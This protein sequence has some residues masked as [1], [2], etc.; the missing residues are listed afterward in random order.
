M[1]KHSRLW[2][3]FL[4]FVSFS[5]LAGTGCTTPDPSKIPSNN[6]IDTSP[7]ADVDRPNNTPG[8]TGVPDDTS[9][10]TDTGPPTDTRPPDPY[11]D[12]ESTATDPG[13]VLKQGT[14]GTLL[15]GIVLTPD[16]ILNPGE[17]LFVDTMIQCVATDCTTHADANNATWIDTKGVISPGLIDSHNHVAYNFL[18]QWF[19]NPFR[20]YSNRYQ[21][22]DE[23]SYEDH[24]RPYAK[25]RS[26]GTH[27]CPAAKWGEL[28]SLIHA[29]TTIQGQSFNQ[30]CINWGVRNADTN[31]HGLGYAHMA[32]NIGSPRDITDSQAAGYMERFKREVNPTT[33]FAVHMTEGIADNN[34]LLEFDSF[35]GRDPRPNRHQGVSLLYNGTSVLIH[36]M[37]MTD[38]QIEEAHL[39]N[40]KV[41]WSP[42]SQI[43]LYG[44]TTPI[45]R[46]LKADIV[47]G[48]GPD[49]TVSGEP[50]MLA[51][52][53]YAKNY[54]HT[55]KI[56]ILTPKK[57]WEMSTWDGALVV[58]LDAHIGRLEPGYRADIAVFGRTSPD[59][60]EAV[61]QSRTQDVRLVYIDGKGMYGDQNLQQS[62]AA[63]QYCEPFDACGKP[64]YICAKESPTATARKNESVDEIRT[65]LYNIMEGIGYPEDEQYK[66]GSEL[67]ELA[68]CD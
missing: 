32:T 21:W 42:S 4:V 38:L 61:I 62:T 63:N 27:F 64:K 14:R 44:T 6:G 39:A 8:D 51:E 7:D 29:T 2:F 16:G 22:A 67:L 53:R 26:T 15:R 28:R 40:A 5:T 46:I 9:P 66:R 58:G 17:V 25:N 1:N 54:A 13:E 60:Y 43:S 47:T 55:E 36:S 30:S 48:I 35:A 31:H 65:Q 41:V 52:L 68:L 18:P 3:F 20:L 57:L 45:E 37:V 12:D 11:P 49:W 56:D 59:P 10:P 34:V 23:K 33:R 24:V 50:D 19:P